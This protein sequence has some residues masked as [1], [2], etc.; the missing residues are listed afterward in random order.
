M[1]ATQT[2]QESGTISHSSFK[3]IL[4][5][6]TF[7]T[8]LGGTI[9]KMMYW[10][11]AD[12]LVLV[13][14]LLLLFTGVFLHKDMA[15]IGADS[16]TTALVTVTMV[17]LVIST[18]FKRM[19]WEGGLMAAYVSVALILLLTLVLILKK[20][21]LRLPKQFGIFTMLYL[22]YIAGAGFVSARAAQAL[23][24]TMP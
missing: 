5:V 9:F 3:T 13:G 16:L 11:G 1:D 17:V 6:L 21:T 23:E 12:M 19:H 20:E 7:I 18:L 24:S 22:I 8:V 10:E 4:N 14:T 15:A 2:T